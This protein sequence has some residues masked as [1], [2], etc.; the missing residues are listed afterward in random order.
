MHSVVVATVRDRPRLCVK[1]SIRDLRSRPSGIDANSKTIAEALH[2]VLTFPTPAPRASM[3]GAFESRQTYRTATYVLL[4][5]LAAEEAP[6]WSSGRA[7]RGPAH[8]SHGRS[9]SF[10]GGHA[11]GVGP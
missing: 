7:L 3:R 1:S 4:R 11:V 2:A 6:P 10:A 5:L 8:M 9:T